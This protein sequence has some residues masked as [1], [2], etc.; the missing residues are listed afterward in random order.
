MLSRLDADIPDALVYWQVSRGTALR[1]HVFPDPAVPPNLLITV[2]QKIMP[3]PDDRVKLI[4][5]PDLRFALCHIKT[6]NLLP[7]VLAHQQAE[8]AGCDEAVLHRDGVV[9]ECSSSA[10]LLLK[11]GA[12]RVRPLDDYILPSTT[13]KHIMETCR[14]LD[15]P[16]VEA[17]FTLE[18]MM[19]ADEILLSCTTTLFRGVDAIDGIPVGGKDPELFERIYG[20]YRRRLL[21]E[22]PASDE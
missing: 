4:T 2:R 5:T 13:R 14:E 16:I 1:S 22:C 21:T 17:A 8:A 3:A 19:D 20:A 15:I 10:L 7:N 9:T 11:D 18:E 6:I 12:L